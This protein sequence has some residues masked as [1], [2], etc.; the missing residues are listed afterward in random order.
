M[1]ITYIKKEVGERWLKEVREI[2]SMLNGL[3][4]RK[5]S[6]LKDYK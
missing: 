1:D 2:S 6:F 5:K 4:K 3:I